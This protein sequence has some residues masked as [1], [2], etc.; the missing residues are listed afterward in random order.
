MERKKGNHL[1]FYDRY[2]GGQYSW[3]LDSRDQSNKST[4]GMKDW[5]DGGWIKCGGPS[6]C[7]TQDY[8]DGNVIMFGYKPCLNCRVNF[9]VF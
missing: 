8:L 9:K 5:F 4:P 6:N 7:D 1:Y 2:E 3:S